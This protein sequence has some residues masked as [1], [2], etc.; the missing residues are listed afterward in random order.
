MNT[1]RLW[2][3]GAIGA[4]AAIGAGAVIL[5]VQPALAAASTADA[6]TAQTEQANSASQARLIGLAKAAATQSALTAENNRLGRAATGSL[7]LNSFSQQ[8]NAAAEID[9][10]SIT[11]V[12]VGEAKD[13]LA[14]VAPA[15]ATPAPAS[16]ATPSATPS[17][18]VSAAPDPAAVEAA[19]VASGLFAKTD[20]LIS[21]GNFTVVP[22]S[23]TV[24]G[25]EA[26]GIGFAQ[27]VQQMFRLYAVD[28]VTFSR[29]TAAGEP[30]STTVS[31]NIYA[32]RR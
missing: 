28:T 9:G 19:A 8:L 17:P 3:V 4:I 2:T 20:P 10:V 15:E 27:D 25:D 23:V 7:R 22:V 13:Y 6:S 29:G 32:L 14:P 1:S 12:N 18:S 11:A 5:G 21:A 26:A 30:S 24:T 16:S 31:G